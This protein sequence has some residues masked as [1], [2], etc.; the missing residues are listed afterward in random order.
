MQLNL[1]LEPQIGMTYADQLAIARRAEALGFP[2]LYRSDHYS[3][4]KEGDD[5]VGS[6]DAWAALA[7][8]ARETTTL[9]LGTLVTPATFRTV[10]NL[11]KTVATVNEMAGAAADGTSRINL[12][13]GTGWMEI[14]HQ[15]HGFEFGSLDTRFRR[16]EEHLEV[17]SK[18]WDPA[19]QPFDFDGEFVTTS[20]SRF[21]PAPEP[22]PRI[23]IGGSG[24]WRT[25]RLAA[26]YAD[27][28]NGVFL[29]VE[30]AGEQRAAV[31]RACERVSRDPSTLAY[32][33]MTR[34]IVGRTRDEF[35]ERAAAS[36]K[37]SGKN[38]SVDDWI[39]ELPP[40]WIVGTTD[41]ARAVLGRFAEVGVEAVMLQHLEY[42]DLDMLDVI[43]E[44]L[45]D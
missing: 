34:C 42:T 45:R 40:D 11:A 7:G 15:R 41:Q 14:E 28:L 25:P 19:A 12:G 13:M 44:D 31:A 32:S 16:L 23:V 21:Y 27:E 6:T 38:G 36:F 22:R 4:G 10:G 17:L 24:L 8:L 39:A 43:A 9:R 3:S 37:R 18:L 30:Q 20:G 35:R 26:Q 29:S 5:G 33:V 1:M 2:A